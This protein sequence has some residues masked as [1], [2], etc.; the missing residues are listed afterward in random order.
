[1]GYVFGDQ[2]EYV[3]ELTPLFW[4]SMFLFASC[5][6]YGYYSG[7][8]LG[9][10]V[11]EEKLEAL[12]NLEGQSYTVV[13]L[14]YFAFIFFSNVLVGLLSIVSG[15]IFGIPA[16]MINA[17][18]GYYSGGIIRSSTLEMGLPFTLSIIIPHGIIE[19]PTFV[20]CWAV[21]LS[22]G[23]KLLSTIR[24]GG[25]LRSEFKRAMRLYVTR[26]VPLLLLAAC[27]EVV[28]TPFFGL[29]FSPI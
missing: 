24:G 4:L 26:L 17:L 27:I 25:G 11:L 15:L 13:I 20:L 22:L 3:R 1:M 9:L 7:S 6:A 2:L 23:Y 5:L 16:L 18:N 10:E 12:P 28:I 14:V 19:I 8:T 21:G 29:L